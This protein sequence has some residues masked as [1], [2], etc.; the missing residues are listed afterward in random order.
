MKFICSKI[1]ILFPSQNHNQD[2]ILDFVGGVSSHCFVPLSYGGGLYDFNTCDKVLLSGVEKVIFNSST[3]LNDFSLVK[4]VSSKYGSQATTL[5]IEVTNT[6]TN[7]G[8]I[9]H[10]NPYIADLSKYIKKAICSGIGEMIFFAKDR[11][12]QNCGLSISLAELVSP[13]T[14]ELPILLSGG[15]SSFDQAF[16]LHSHFHISGCLIG[17]Q[18]SFINN[19]S[20]SI[21]VNTSD[22]K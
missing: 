6:F 13:F 11:D 12:G 7:T 10:C 5:M 4:E 18:F 20:N 21:L 3:I 14:K 15:F 1:S 2:S 9:A 16:Y 22:T 19:S 8:V 17:F